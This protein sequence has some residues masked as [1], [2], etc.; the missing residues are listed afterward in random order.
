MTSPGDKTSEFFNSYAH[1][2]NAIYGGGTGAIQRT[3]SRLFRKSMMIRYMKVIDGCDPIEDRTVIDIGCGPGHYGI[4]LASKGAAHVVGM[5]F[6]G[7]MIELARRN[8]AAAGVAD[9][10][11]FV[12]DDFL[13]CEIKEKF[14][15]SILMG[16]MDYIARPEEMIAKA[17]SVTT[18]KAFFSFPAR[19]GFLAWQRR[20][21]YR[22][23]CDLYLYGKDQLDR[24]FEGLSGAEAGIERIERDFFVTVRME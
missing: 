12:T 20:M 9:K 14:D 11:R 8:A 10:C 17:L 23:K 5:D 21:R 19:G 2:F 18:R 16:L 22:R 13:T 6:A 7:A 24:L 15:Y 3:I 4:A 1:D